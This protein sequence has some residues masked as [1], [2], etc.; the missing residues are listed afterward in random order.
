MKNL[1]YNLSMNFMSI[2]ENMYLNNK[3]HMYPF[4]YWFPTELV[5]QIKMAFLNTQNFFTEVKN[6]E[7]W[8]NQMTKKKKK[9]CSE[10]LGS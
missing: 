3:N 7:V 10:F 6:E 4:I 1:R 2:K 8:R 5:C 9:N